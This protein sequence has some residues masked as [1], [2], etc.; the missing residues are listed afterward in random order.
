MVQSLESPRGH[1]KEGNAL[2][3]I[4]KHVFAAKFNK[5]LSKYIRVFSRPIYI[6]TIL[7][8]HM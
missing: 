6:K 1:Y 7:H 3:F 2:F 4:M 8:T 5:L